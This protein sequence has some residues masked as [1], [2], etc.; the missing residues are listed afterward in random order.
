MNSWHCLVSCC[1]PTKTNISQDLGA[2]S[3]NKHLKSADE[4]AQITWL[5]E[6]WPRPLQIYQPSS[7]NRQTFSNL[8]V[9]C[10]GNP[11]KIYPLI[12]VYNQQPLNTEL[13]SQNKDGGL[14]PKM[15][16]LVMEIPRS[17]AMCS[18]SSVFTFGASIHLRFVSISAQENNVPCSKP[19]TGPLSA[20]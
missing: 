3:N 9:N 4:T 14:C 7:V 16:S 15:T 13:P 5:A 1:R 6:A 18:L 19:S 11:A 17:L 8:P 10:Q 20:S 2:L 12:N